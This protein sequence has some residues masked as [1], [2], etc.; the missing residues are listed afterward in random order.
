MKHRGEH[1]VSIVRTVFE[2]E[3]TYRFDG[4]VYPPALLE[5]LHKFMDSLVVLVPLPLEKGREKDVT[6]SETRDGGSRFT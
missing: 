2:K 5:L 4:N 3:N 1:T 6:T